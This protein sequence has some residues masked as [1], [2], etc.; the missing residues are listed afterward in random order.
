MSCDDSYE[1]EENDEIGDDFDNYETTEEKL[2]DK[3]LPGKRKVRKMLNELYNDNNLHDDNDYVDEE[4]F[5]EDEPQVVDSYE[6]REIFD[7]EDN[8]DNGYSENENLPKFTYKPKSTE[9]KL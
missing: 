3:S 2:K 7:F 8:P 9:N 6:Q 4:L 5:N 1:N